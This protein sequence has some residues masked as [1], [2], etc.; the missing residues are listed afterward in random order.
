M[1]SPYPGQRQLP[2]LGEPL[3]AGLLP[4]AADPG[5]SR[6]M[7][8]PVDRGE[9]DNNF[10]AVLINLKSLLDAGALTQEEFDN[11]KAEILKRF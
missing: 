3:N 5:L 1:G 11:K 7:A 4:V 6:A 2:A 8:I 10:Q 9:A